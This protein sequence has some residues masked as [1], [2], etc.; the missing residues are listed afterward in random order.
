MRLAD[1]ILQILIL[2]TF[3]SNIDT[4]STPSSQPTNYYNV[5]TRIEPKILNES[6]EWSMEYNYGR[7]YKHSE[8]QEWGNGYSNLYNTGNAMKNRNEEEKKQ[9]GKKLSQIAIASPQWW[10]F[11]NTDESREAYAVNDDEQHVESSKLQFNIANKQFQKKIG[12]EMRSWYNWPSKNLTWPNWVHKKNPY[13]KLWVPWWNAN[14]EQTQKA[15]KVAKYAYDKINTEQ[16]QFFWPGSIGWTG[17]LGPFGQ[18]P[19]PPWFP[20]VFTDNCC[21]I[22]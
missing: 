4:A 2:N 14:N 18:V 1:K 10:A 19:T 5:D 3:L 12:S 17:D 16:N 15:Q 22:S 21:K 6:G 13:E 11:A 8:G 20:K 7:N 9:R